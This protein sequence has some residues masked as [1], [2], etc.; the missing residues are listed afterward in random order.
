YCSHTQIG[1]NHQTIE[2]NRQPKPIPFYQPITDNNKNIVGFEVLARHFDNN[3]YKSF[4]FNELTR[5]HTLAIDISILQSVFNEFSMMAKKNVTF[6]SLNLTPAEPSWYYCKIL[7]DTI[8][9]AQRNNITIW[10]EI[11]E[12]TPLHPLHLILLQQL[13]NY[14]VKIALDDFG[15]KENQFQRL[16]TI[17][18]DVVK[19]DRQL[20]LQAAYSRYSQ[21]MF[22]KLVGYFQSTGK[23]VVCEGVETQQQLSLVINAGFDF[24]QGYK[25][26][27]PRS[28]Y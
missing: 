25:L 21:Q 17:E 26:G 16:L 3:E 13:K 27:K 5:D 2:Y 7:L 15:T 11:P 24:I 12:H 18:C 10:I 20:L 28:Y 8:K 6:I 19:F 23:Q 22:E 1:L 9:E 14:P 4:H